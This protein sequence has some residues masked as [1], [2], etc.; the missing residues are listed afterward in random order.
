VREVETVFEINN[1]NSSSSSSSVFSARIE[2]SS[3]ISSYWLSI[4]AATQAGT[5]PTQYL[6][7]TLPSAGKRNVRCCSLAVVINFP[8]LT[9]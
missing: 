8:T 6:L 1:N 3:S 7:V 5:S 2:L 4:Q 9:D